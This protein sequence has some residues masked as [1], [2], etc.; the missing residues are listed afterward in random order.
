[1]LY[2][3]C[4]LYVHNGY[5]LKSK[6]FKSVIKLFAQELKDARLQLLFLTELYDITFIKAFYIFLEKKINSVAWSLKR[7]CKYFAVLS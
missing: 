6:N 2:L 3:T 7:Q 4:T 1:M 5:I